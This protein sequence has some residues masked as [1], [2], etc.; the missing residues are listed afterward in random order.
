[1]GNE[2]GVFSMEIMH[3][4]MTGL[5]SVLKVNGAPLLYRYPYRNSGE[6]MRADWGRIGDDVES[7]MGRINNRYDDGR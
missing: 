5:L 4:F 3:N 2:K 7:V 1:M 6:G